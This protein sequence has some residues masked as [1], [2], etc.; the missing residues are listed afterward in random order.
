[1]IALQCGRIY[2]DAEI[3]EDVPVTLAPAE[4]LQCGRIYKDAEMLSTPLYNPR[5]VNSLQCGRIYKDAEMR[6]RVAFTN[7]L[8]LPSMWPHL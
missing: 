2:K 4:L 5:P 8:H 1:M 7:P 6:G 3:Y